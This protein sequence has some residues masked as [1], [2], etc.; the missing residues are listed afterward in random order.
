MP[1]YAQLAAEAVWGRE[2]V[3]PAVR[4]LGDALCAHF[5]RPR[6]AAGTKGDNL[7]LSGSHRS[8]EWLLKSRFAT[9][10]RYTVED[11]L[12]DE[13]LRWIAGF[14]FTPASKAEMLTICQRLDKAVRAGLVEEIAAWY[15]NLDGDQRV[16]GYDN[17]RNVAATSDSSHLWHLHITFKR[18]YAGD[19]A[20]MRKVFAILTGAPIPG[21]PAPSPSPAPTVRRAAWAAAAEETAMKDWYFTKGAKTATVYVGNGMVARA[22]PNP[23]SWEAMKAKVAAAKG[24]A[25]KDIPLEEYP[26]DATA[27]GVAGTVL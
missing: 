25:V 23:A 7:H 14:D 26:D 27:R 6:T 12:N 1:T 16:D 8:Q 10:R 11:D 22:L 19:M 20:V 13:Q 3:T 5:K 18:R 2:I 21:Q 15:G 17:V 24:V 4:W 9:N